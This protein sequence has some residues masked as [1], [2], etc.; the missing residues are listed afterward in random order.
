MKASKLN[1]NSEKLRRKSRP[2]F[3]LLAPQLQP[4]QTASYADQLGEAECAAVVYLYQNT[5]PPPC[6][7]ATTRACLHREMPLKE[8]KEASLEESVIN[9]SQ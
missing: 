1:K 8:T 2:N 3:F 7:H 4:L 5:P 9:T 6:P